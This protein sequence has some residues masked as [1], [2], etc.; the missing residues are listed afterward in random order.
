MPTREI[1]LRKDSQLFA[2]LCLA[3][4]REGHSVQFRVQGESMRPN[5]LDGD[6]VLVAPPADRELRQ[7]DIALVQNQDGLRV[8]RV[9]SCDVSSGAVVTRSDTG[10]EPDPSASRMFGKVVVLRRNSHEESLTPLQT[11]VVH[12]LRVMFRRMRAAAMLRLRR[13]ALLLSGI[14]ALSFL[15]A[16][17]LAPAVNAQTADLQLTQTASATAVAAG[18]TY[19]YTE[20]VKNNTSSA[21]VT[22]GT[23]TVYMQTPPNTVYETYA[24]TDWNCTNPGANNVGPVICTYNTTLASGATASTLTINFQVSAGTASGT[25]IQNSATVTNSTFVDGTP[26]NNTSITS[27]VV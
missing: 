11:R 7:G 13:F 10:L 15:Y 22:T 16:T 2:Q 9:A 19:T 25:T 6:S 24:G 1:Q 14:V 4:L 8:H 12:P 23:I 5:I 21:T 18:S 20:V 26:A 27:I 17:F 3:L